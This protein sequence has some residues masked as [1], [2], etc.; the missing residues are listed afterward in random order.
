M[1]PTLLGAMCLQ[2]CGVPPQ[3]LRGLLSAPVYRFHRFQGCTGFIVI[4]VSQRFYGFYIF[5]DFT[6]FHEFVGFIGFWGITALATGFECA[7][8]HKFSSFTCTDVI[9]FTSLWGSHIF[10]VLHLKSQ[11][12]NVHSFYKC[13]QMFINVF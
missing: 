11:A 1:S 12:S 3:G 13:F 5:L 10:G 6:S 9:S 4:S 7:K 8:F 2:V